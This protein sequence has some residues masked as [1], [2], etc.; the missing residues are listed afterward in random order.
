VESNALQLR[1]FLYE[2]AARSR[3][4]RRRTLRK[5]ICLLAGTVGP[6]PDDGTTPV[7]EP[8]WPAPTRGPAAARCVA[9]RADDLLKSLR[10][11]DAEQ[12]R[13]ALFH[14]QVDN[15]RVVAVEEQYRP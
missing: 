13:G 15:G 1:R 8:R 4:G 6:R 3:R 7:R 2:Q 12:T 5:Q 10:T 14:L 11:S 9:P